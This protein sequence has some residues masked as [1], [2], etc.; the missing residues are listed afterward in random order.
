MND[1]RYDNAKFGFSI[2][3]PNG[4]QVH[5]RGL[6]A[7]IL[8]RTQDVVVRLVPKGA[9]YPQ[10]GVYV[11]ETKMSTSEDVRKLMDDVAASSGVDVIQSESKKIGGHLGHFVS[12]RMNA[13]PGAL[14]LVKAAVVVRSNY[15]L[16]QY[17]SDDLAR[18]NA[19]I[20]QSLATIDFLR[21]VGEGSQAGKPDVR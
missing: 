7:K 3:I 2:A 20:H 11:R 14:R 8:N 12:Y 21:R 9:K 1:D 19:A 10:L 18:D 4:W 5:E 6:L 13:S 17:S 16:F 15:Y